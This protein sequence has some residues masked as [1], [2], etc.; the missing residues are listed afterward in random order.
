MKLLVPIRV[1]RDTEAGSSPEDQKD[2]AISYADTREDVEI[3]FSDVIDINVS[4]ATPIAEREGVREWLTPHKINEWDAIGIPEMSRLSRDLRDYLN[5]VYDVIDK[6]GKV[7]VDMSDGTDTSTEDGKDVLIGRVLAAMQYRKFVARKR[8]NKAQRTSD[9]GKWDGGRIPFGYAPE[10]RVYADQFGRERTAY[11]L[12]RDDKGTADTVR[13]MINS[14]LAGKSHRQ[15]A[16]ELNAECIWTS[17]GGKWQ[18]STVR[19]VLTSPALAGYVVKMNGSHQEIRRDKQERPIRFVSDE[20]AILTEDEWRELQEILKARGRKR[21]M[22]QARHM[23]WDVVFCGNCSQPCEDELPCDKHDVRMY[24]QRRIKDTS[25][26]NVYWCKKCNLSIHLDLLENYVEWRLVNEAGNRPLLE[27]REI[28]GDD[29][30]SSEIHKLRRQI[31]RLRGELDIT[32]D[33]EDL[34]A[35]IRKRETQLAELDSGPRRP[36]S[37]VLVPVEPRTTIAEHWHELNDAKARNDYLRA[38]VATFYADRDGITGQ[39]GWMAL[40][41]PHADLEGM[42]RMMRQLKLPVRHEWSDVKSRLDRALA[43]D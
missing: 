36:D 32:P 35:L 15:I 24:G 4:G 31:E 40:D 1:S 33:D 22:A 26:P 20:D 16:A 27:R 13:R 34:T 18:D 11:Y 17:L 30:R 19:R 23:L 41:D 37:V 3:I 42:R 43:S 2:T 12:V 10:K 25:K 5:F 39:L 8:S 14:A 9:E 6:R 21:G 7:V 29:G 38:T 28:S